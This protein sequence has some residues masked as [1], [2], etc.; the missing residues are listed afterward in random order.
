MV[1]QLASRIATAR[2]WFGSR[3][4]AHLWLR[5]CDA[6][7]ANTRTF[8]RPHVENQGRIVIGSRVRIN[9]HWA[10]VALV[11]G[12]NGEIDIGDGVYINYGTLI[13]AHSRV[14]IGAD[15]MVGN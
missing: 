14:R 4:G 13:S 6:V 11:T 8:W 10:P 12:P 3:L 7:G 5:R 9:S 15:V 1:R 2:T